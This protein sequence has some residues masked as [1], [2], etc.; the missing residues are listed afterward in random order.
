MVDKENVKISKLPPNVRLKTIE[1]DVMV[2]LPNPTKYRRNLDYHLR[3]NE[4]WAVGKDGVWESRGIWEDSIKESLQSVGKEYV[5]DPHYQG[6]WPTEE[7]LPEDNAQYLLGDYFLWRGGRWSLTPGGWNQILEGDELDKQ[8]QEAGVVTITEN[9]SSAVS[10]SWFEKAQAA[11]FTGTYEQWKNQNKTYPKEINLLGSYALNMPLPDPNVFK[12]GDAFF[13]REHIWVKGESGRWEETPQGMPEGGLM[14]FTPEDYRAYL[15]KSRDSDIDERLMLASDDDWHDKGSMARVLMETRKENKRLK[16]NRF[17]ASVVLKLVVLGILGGLGYA[18][19]LYIM[20]S[21]TT[22]R[23]T[24][25]RTCK[26]SK[27][28]LTITG[29]RTFSYPY[30]TLF[31]FRLVDENKVLIDTVMNVTGDKITVTGLNSK[32]YWQSKASMGE[33]GIMILR[34][35]DTYIF[36]TDKELIVATSNGFCNPIQRELDKDELKQPELDIIK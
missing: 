14:P 30:K 4:L 5:N 18:G 8:L 11:G 13:W 32:K 34:D 15:E 25:E 36:Q 22:G 7:D 12:V 23:Y 9:T 1:E 17:I 28:N 29:K 16:R 2:P 33:R 31:G 10:R 3:G 6:V 20:A 35:A 21:I 27:G 24:D 19:Y 26:I